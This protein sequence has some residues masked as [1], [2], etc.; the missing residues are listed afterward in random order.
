MEKLIL[1]ELL[2]E[3]NRVTELFNEQLKNTLQSLEKEINLYK[4]DAEK[5]KE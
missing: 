2:F 5:L 3:S 1:H 4:A